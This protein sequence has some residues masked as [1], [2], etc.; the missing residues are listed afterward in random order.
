[1]GKKKRH[2]IKMRNNLIRNRASEW[3][4]KNKGVYFNTPFL[5]EQLGLNPDNKKHYDS[6]Y[7]TVICY[8]RNH[9]IKYYKECKKNG[10]LEG[11][12]RYK[13]WTVML[14]N[15]N[16]NDA[17]VFL[18]EPKKGYY[19]QPSFAELEEMDKV[20]LQKQWKGI[21]TVID[22]MQTIDANVLLDSG[23]EIPVK[24]LLKA[25]KKVDNLLDGEK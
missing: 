20:R 3:L 24:D 19:I 6:V 7:S 4:R 8:W 10:D 5:V 25:G 21:L 16:M 14:Y 2:P 17:Y 1:M 22:E 12:D 18:F 15:F 13:A 23:K 9:F 11:L